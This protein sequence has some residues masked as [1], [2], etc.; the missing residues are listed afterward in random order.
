MPLRRYLWSESAPVWP[1][2]ATVAL[3]SFIRL[4]T[5]ELW[6][7]EGRWAVICARMIRSGD[8][9]HPY[10]FNVPYYDKPLLSYWLMIAAARAIGRLN[11]LALRLPVALSGVLAVW[12]TVQVGSKRFGRTTGLIAGYLLGTCVMFVF[13]SRVA[14]ADMMN[15]AGTMAAMAWYFE[16]KEDPGFTT[17]AVFFLILAVTAL[18]KGLIGPAL[19]ILVLIPEWASE[20]DWRRWLRP[21]LLPALLLALVVYL[22]PFLLSSLNAPA[23]YGESGLAMV[24]RENAVRYLDPFDHQEPVYTYLIDAPVYLLPWSLFLPFVIWKM[25]RGW[26]ES[27]PASRWIAWSCLLIFLFLTASGSRRSYYVLP[28]LPFATL[29]IADW[30]V[31]AG[32]DGNAKRAAAWTVAGVSALLL[33]WF[34]VASPFGLRYGGQRHFAREVRATAE[35]A[36][37]WREWRML[38]CG[39]PPSIGYYIE[40]ETE[41]S[42]VDWTDQ[43]GIRTF[44]DANPRTILVTKRRFLESIH[45]LVPAAAMVDEPPRLPG[46]LRS[47]RDSGRDLVALLSSTGGK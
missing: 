17:F 10:L 33:F 1:L 7:L 11:E 31:S 12:C 23:G 2:L 26:Q 30:L 43:Q 42:V 16:R 20:R 32:D 6:T 35:K 38:Q 44:L 40:T 3:L 39:A 5:P 47:H 15:V 46:F 37:P 9:L 41:P 21:A 8:Y 4:G 22:A 24:F 27:S 18:T 28:L 19:A 34:G 45:A 36:A 29:M 14:S 13:W 25:I